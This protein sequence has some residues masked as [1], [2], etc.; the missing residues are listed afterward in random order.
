MKLNLLQTNPGNKGKVLRQAKQLNSGIDGKKIKPPPQWNM[1]SFNQVIITALSIIEMCSVFGFYLRVFWYKLLNGR[2]SIK[3]VHDLGEGD[4]V[5]GSVVNN[6]LTQREPGVVFHPPVHLFFGVCNGPKAFL[7]P[8]YMPLIL[9]KTVAS[10]TSLQS[11][12]Q[13][14]LAQGL[15]VL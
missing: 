11:L 8:S 5:E 4:S 15:A 12:S 9:P 14:S 10:C 13:Y 7:M 1:V 2:L 3:F 6:C